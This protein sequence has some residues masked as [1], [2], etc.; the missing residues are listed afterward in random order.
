V[1][2]LACGTGS[3]LKQLEPNY[4][5]VGVDRSEVMLALAAQ[6]RSPMGP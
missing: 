3:I 1:L 6:K 2:E 4:K 5:L